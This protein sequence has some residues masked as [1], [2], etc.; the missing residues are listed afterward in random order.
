MGDERPPSLS[1]TARTEFYSNIGVLVGTFDKLAKTIDNKISKGDSAPNERLMADYQTTVDVV[2]LF[3]DIRF[4]CLA[5]VTAIITIANA[6]IPGT[7]NPG[8]RIA[9]G[10]VGL[11]ATLGITIYDLRNS[12]LY[13]AAIHRAKDLE[14]RLGLNS[15]TRNWEKEGCFPKGLRM[16]RT[17]HGRISPLNSER[18]R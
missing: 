1:E 3:S 17:V 13:D 4:R 14:R 2:K 15:A 6:L 10:I 18:T 16:L 9:L 7:G 12:Q 5:F 11:V 8:T